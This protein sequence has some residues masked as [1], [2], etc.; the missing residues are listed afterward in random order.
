MT[1]ASDHDRD[2]PRRYTVASASKG[3]AKR[4]FVPCSL[5]PGVAF[6]M[7]G[8]DRPAVRAKVNTCRVVRITGHRWPQNIEIAAFLRLPDPTRF[9]AIAAIP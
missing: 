4:G 3:K 6:V 2:N 7:A 5:R 9:P 1:R 8:Q